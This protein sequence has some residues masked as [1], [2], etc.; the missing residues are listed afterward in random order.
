[1]HVGNMPH[2]RPSFKDEP[3]VCVSPR[4]D[5]VCVVACSWQR[6]ADMAPTWLSKGPTGPFLGLKNHVRALELAS[7]QSV[8]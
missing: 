6:E 7:Q 3:L 1:M 5:Q 8:G 4:Q 2:R